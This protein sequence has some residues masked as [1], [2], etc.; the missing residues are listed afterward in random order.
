MMF[1]DQLAVAGETGLSRGSMGYGAVA[2]QVLTVPAMFA[3]FG[4]SIA[5]ICSIV[6]V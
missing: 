6:L 4:I 2:A 3:L 1:M 5:I